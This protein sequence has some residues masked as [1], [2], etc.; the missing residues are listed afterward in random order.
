MITLPRLFI[1]MA[2]TGV[3]LVIGWTTMHM[4]HEQRS[5]ELSAKPTSPDQISIRLLG[6]AESISGIEVPKG[7]PEAGDTYLRSQGPADV[8]VVLPEGQTIR[9][10]AKYVSVDVDHGVVVDVHILPLPNNVPYRQALLDLRRLMSEMGIAPDALMREQMAI[11][12]DDSPGI[13]DGFRPLTYTTGVKINSNVKFSVDV[14][15]AH[16]GGWFLA[17]MFSAIG[18]ARR[19]VWDPTFK[20]APKPDE[21]KKSRL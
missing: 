10:R 11:W 2:S 9:Q 6:A 1:T 7:L 19:S 15:P 13:S 16:D 18:D 5:T 20:A 3:V 17:L 21:R 12:P 8:T 14:R 4:P